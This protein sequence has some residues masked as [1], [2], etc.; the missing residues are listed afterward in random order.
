MSKTKEYL[1][2]LEQSGDV[3][4]DDD[5]FYYPQD[6]FLDEKA[7][8]EERHKEFMKTLSEVIDN[9]EKWGA[10]YGDGI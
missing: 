8:E 9:P 2:S 7:L 5:Y 6:L 3:H 4:L 1:E 10:E